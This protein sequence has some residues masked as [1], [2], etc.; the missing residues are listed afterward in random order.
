M[1]H[2]FYKGAE[3][4]LDIEDRTLA[5]LRLVFMTKLRRGEP[6]LFITT[7]PHGN[8]PREF[9][10]HPSLPLQFR[11]VGSRLPQI[12]PRWIDVLMDSANSSAGLHVIRE[13]SG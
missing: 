7:S 9:W 2:L 10:I 1:G 5:H 8:A 11:F 12:N 6:F 4:P 13:P 3:G